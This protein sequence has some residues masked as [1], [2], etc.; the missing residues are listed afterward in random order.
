MFIK[1]FLI[2]KFPIFPILSKSRSLLLH[3]DSL[4]AV[5]ES[6]PTRSLLFTTGDKNC[7]NEYLEFPTDK[8]FNYSI[9]V[10]SSERSTTT[11]FPFFLSSHKRLCTSDE[12]KNKQTNK[13]KKHKKHKKSYESVSTGCILPIGHSVLLH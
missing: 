4:V 3:L 5:I 13:T 9:K 2:W 8:H 11:A 6:K 12:T 7:N 1:R 10:Q